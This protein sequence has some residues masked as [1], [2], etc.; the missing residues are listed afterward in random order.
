MKYILYKRP[1]SLDTLYIVQYLHSIGIEIR[2]Y[3]IIER[4]YPKEITRLP[5]I[6]DQNTGITYAGLTQVINFYETN[7]GIQN[8]LSKAKE[9][10]ENNP[11][12]TIK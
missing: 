10:K 3:T 7:T 4:N 11:N 8:L 12:Y 6:L 2:P 5:S 9:F 1:I